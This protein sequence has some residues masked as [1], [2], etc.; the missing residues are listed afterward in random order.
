MLL[1]GTGV[2]AG[3]A[4]GTALV[5]TCGCRSPAPRRK[6]EAS[7]VEGERARFEAALA[8]AA[9]DL[10][11]L[12]R[13]VRERLGPS[14][15]DVFG[16]QLL[17]LEDRDFH[18]R[19]VHALEQEKVNV[20]AA[21]SE[22]ID[23][24]TRR[25]DAVSD[26]YLRERAAD[27]RDVGRRVLSSLL[28]GERPD[29]LEL[30]DGAI[31]VADELL[32][33]VTARLQLEH[34]RGLVTERGHRF[35]HSSILARSLRTPAVV[36]VLGAPEQIK[37]GDRVV[38]DGVAGVVFV[39]PEARVEREYDRV[40]E[41]LRAQKEEL[42]KFVSV[43]S[44]TRD[45]ATIPLLANVNK[46]ADTEAALL[47]GAEGIGL[48]RTEFA[49][50]IRPHPPTEEEQYE[51][52]A[53]AAERFHPRRVVFRLLDLGGD[54]VL[55]YLPLPP[56]R[57]PS[58]A[59]RGI[60]LLLRHRDLLKTQLRAFLRVSAGHPVSILLPVVGGVEEIRE[61]RGVVRQVQDDLKAAGER[62]DP[63]IPVGAMI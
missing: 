3:V 10:V 21:L 26:G 63:K 40:E 11:T 43:P 44:V 55:P 24:Y 16:A 42:R 53:R 5:I 29:G 32:P 45:G 34:V 31:V 37:T 6:I 52:L 18:D 4:K 56:S 15:A 50:S 62:F 25:L 60:R 22:V 61:A 1:R 12:Q 8:R 59:A 14:Q 54:K 2:S 38:V 57:N 23:G 28:E 30:P 19:V 20:E 47:H 35:S 49:F 27:I 51:F 41:E 9:A 39:N 13:D 7:E 58:L 36:G 48:Y 17:A 46:L 33:S